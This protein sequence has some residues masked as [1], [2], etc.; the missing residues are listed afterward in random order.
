[1]IFL[2]LNSAREAIA[3]VAMR[4]RQGGHDIPDAIVRRRFDKGLDNFH[5]RY[6]HAVDA[7]TLYDASGTAPALLDWGNTA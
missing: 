7:W 3:R 4:V 5:D 6:T 1:M 2:K